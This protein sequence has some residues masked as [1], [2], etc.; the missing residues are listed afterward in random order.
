MT[1]RTFAYKPERHGDFD[2]LLKFVEETTP[3]EFRQRVEANRN[4]VWEI[5]ET[6]GREFLAL[7]WPGEVADRIGHKCVAFSDATKEAKGTHLNV[8]REEVVYILV[9]LIGERNRKGLIEPFIRLLKEFR[10]G[11]E[12]H[13]IGHVLSRA[14][15]RCLSRV[16]SM[17]DL[18][19]LTSGYRDRF[20][21]ARNQY[22]FYD[23]PTAFAE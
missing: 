8:I 5:L 7:P 22:Y 13:V 9:R 15:A 1:E 11:D 10:I 16:G 21:P 14:D 3:D 18:S 23:D 17:I 20:D 2:R 19:K 6:F 12:R 4:D